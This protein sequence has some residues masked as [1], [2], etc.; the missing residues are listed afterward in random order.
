MEDSGSRS[1]GPAGTEQRA[2]NEA[3]SG[4]A[5]TLSVRTIKVG[6]LGSIV[7]AGWKDLVSAPRFGLGIGLFYAAGGWLI[8]MLLWLFALPYLAY[9]M[10]MGF[11]LVAPFVVT[12]LYDISRRLERGEPLS[13]NT[14][15]GSVWDARQRD[16][17]WMALVT[18]FALV[19]W[20][21]IA[22]LLFFGFLGLRSLDADLLR[23]VF[24]TQTGI[25]FLGLGHAVGAL[26]AF[27]VFSISVVSFPLLFDRDVDFVTAMTTS[28][29]VVAANPLPMMI[30][31]S[32]IA[33][34]VVASIALA[35]TGLIVVLPLLGHSSWHLYRRVVV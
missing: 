32:L 27:A 26:I 6:E 35:F 14:L 16:L 23:D 34:L 1:G 19:I 25:I 18:A 9:P 5:K 8:L 7:A 2:D 17:R 4:A 28:V 3:G 20:L 29:R 31:C 10:A 24:T 30:W 21:D 22:A 11:A 15:L 12:G 13:W 33:V